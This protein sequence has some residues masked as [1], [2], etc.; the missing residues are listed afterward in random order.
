IHMPQPSPPR[1][2]SNL[3]RPTDS[4]DA[5][6]SPSAPPATSHPPPATP[7]A[8]TTM[9][10]AG[11]SLM[12]PAI[13]NAPPQQDEPRQDLPRPYKCPICPKAFHRL[14]H[15]TRHIRP[16]TGEK[17]H[18]CQF[19]GCTKR[20]SRSDELTRHSRIH[21]NPNSRRGKGQQ[22]QHAAALQAAEAAA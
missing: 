2:F 4:N 7:P 6:L 5:Q 20:F 13:Q 14:E 22:Q 8:S 18:V 1:D 15:Q 19:P 10:A 11:V 17:P 16:H 21:N 3:L 12:T 9:A